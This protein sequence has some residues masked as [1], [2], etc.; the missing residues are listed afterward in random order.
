ML[1]MRASYAEILRGKGYK[2]TPK[3]KA[4]LGIMRKYNRYFSPSEIWGRLKGKFD[5]LGLPSIYRIL[6]EFACAGIVTR[7]KR[8]DRQLY[9]FL[10]DAADCHHHH[11]ICRQC[12]CVSEVLACHADLIYGYIENELGCKAEAHFMQI[13]GLCAKCR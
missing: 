11:F 3:R 8:D 13:E 1:M 7:I 12:H 5:C 2:V 9:Y 4:V 10:C 6:E